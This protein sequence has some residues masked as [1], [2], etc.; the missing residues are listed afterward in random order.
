MDSAEHAAKQTIASLTC[1]RPPQPPPPR[2]LEMLPGAPSSC[3]AKGLTPTSAV[4]KKKVAQQSLV[5]IATLAFFL[6]FIKRYKTKIL[7]NYHNFNGKTHFHE[8]AHLCRFEAQSCSGSGLA[9]RGLLLHLSERGE[10]NEAANVPLML[11]GAG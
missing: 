9:G 2:G 4:K 8:T 3:A 5:A 6:A 1:L 11:Q 7:K 10:V